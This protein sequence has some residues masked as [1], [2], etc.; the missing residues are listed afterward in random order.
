MDQTDY[1]FKAE[2]QA[3]FAIWEVGGKMEP[4]FGLKTL[5]TSEKNRVAF[6]RLQN[7]EPL[8]K[9]MVSGLK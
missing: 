3:P 9:P 5:Y 2:M 7:P 8:R 1:L 4:T 6:L